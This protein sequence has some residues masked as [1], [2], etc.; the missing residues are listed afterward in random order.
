MA[1][2]A[3]SVRLITRQTLGIRSLCNRPATFAVQKYLTP[4]Q[5]LA[6]RELLQSNQV[7]LF[8]LT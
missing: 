3:R 2:I 4:K 5:N 8:R 6:H 1:G 7:S